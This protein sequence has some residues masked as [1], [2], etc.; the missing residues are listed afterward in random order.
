M[1]QLRRLL[2]PSFSRLIIVL[3]IFG[4]VGSVLFGSTV[5]AY[6]PTAGGLVASHLA[7]LQ[8]LTQPP[9]WKVSVNPDT[10]YIR[11]P[12]CDASFTVTVTVIKPT[13]Q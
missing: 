4:S 6:A 3:V 12:Q 9:P 1:T 2:P 8:T 13:R 7:P 11:P 5:P 10:I